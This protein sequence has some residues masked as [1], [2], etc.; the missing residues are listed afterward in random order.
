MTL[1]SVVGFLVM[2]GVLVPKPETRATYQYLFVISLGYGHLI[3]GAYF[4]RHRIASLAPRQ[5]PGS[6]FW[7]WVVLGILNL[8]ALYGWVAS[9]LSLAFAP[10]VAVSV[11]HTVENDL[12]LARA[13]EKN[14]SLTPVL[15]GWAENLISFGL[16]AWILALS[17]AVLVSP[18]WG[19]ELGSGSLDNRVLRWVSGACG[20]G[21]LLKGTGAN[22]VLGTLLVAASFLL[23]TQIPANWPIRFSDVFTLVTLY[24]LVSWLVFWSDRLR[25]AEPTR[26][27]Q[28]HRSLAVVHLPPFALCALLAIAPHPAT[29]LF[30]EAV[31]SPAIY[32][33][34][35]IL[36]VVQTA[37]VR[38]RSLRSAA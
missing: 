37:L 5:V 32:L 11:W 7:A 30:R 17:A 9:Y 10:L 1:S 21:L 12:A 14:L 23:P 24:H 31:F 25:I 8:F 13:Y 4:A 27:R 33:F 34:W 26:R 20:C 22:R 29:H 15:R 6:L 38:G 2:T 18:E 35:S 36:H 3:G 19:G 28:I 16:S